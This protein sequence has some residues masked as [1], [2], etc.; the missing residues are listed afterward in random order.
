MSRNMEDTRAR[1]QGY[2]LSSAEQSVVNRELKIG[3]IR[4]FAG[5][6]LALLGSHLLTRRMVTAGAMGRGPRVLF[7]TAATVAGAYVPAVYSA[8]SA[9]RSLMLLEDS[10]LGQEAKLILQDYVPSAPVTK[11]HQQ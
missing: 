7:M 2:V 9:L 5:A 10:V 1:L 8:R 6:S 3:T 4:V 11:E